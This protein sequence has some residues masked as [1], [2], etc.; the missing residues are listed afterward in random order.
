M[1]GGVATGGV[2]SGAID[3]MTG[4]AVAINYT[5]HEVHGGSSFVTDFVDSSMANDETII[6]AFK[7]PAGDKR[8]HLFVEYTSLVGGEL[9][10]WEGPT[11]T[12]QTGG[13][14]PIVNRNRKGT[15]ASSVVLAN[16]A[17]AGFV[18]ADVVNRNPTGLSTVAAVSLHHFYSWGIKN[19]VGAGAARDLEEM[20]LKADTTYA[21]VFTAEGGS[22]TGQVIL[23]WYEHTDR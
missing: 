1:S 21:A 3:T 10:L 14:E 23:N 22:N 4:A 16:Q 18:A 11:W 9:Q 17:Q 12:A 20:I 19:R 5:H 7:T 8:L 13:E 2:A 6:L 15:P